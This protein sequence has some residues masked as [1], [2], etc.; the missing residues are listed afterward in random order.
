MNSGSRNIGLDDGQMGSHRTASAAACGAHYDLK[1]S[2]FRGHQ[3]PKGKNLTVLKSCLTSWCV[4]PIL[5]K[6]CPLLANAMKS[7]RPTTWKS[8]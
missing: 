5:Y 8:C 4:S 6:N 7:W 3:L 2:G 1:Q